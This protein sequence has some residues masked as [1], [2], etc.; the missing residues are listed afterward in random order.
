M[1]NAGMSVMG[2]DF[3][4]AKAR[5]DTSR[6]AKKAGHVLTSEFKPSEDAPDELIFFY[7]NEAVKEP[8]LE[9]IKKLI[10]KKNE[11]EMKAVWDKLKKPDTE[12]LY[13]RLVFA[14]YRGLNCPEPE[15]ITNKQKYK[16]VMKIQKKARELEELIEKSYWLSSVHTNSGLLEDLKMF[17]PEDSDLYAELNMKGVSVA[18]V[19]L[20]FAK[21]AEE[22]AKEPIP[23]ARAKTIRADDVYLVKSLTKHMLS[24][25]SEKMRK[26]VAIIASVVTGKTIAIDFVK[27]NTS[28]RANY[29]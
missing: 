23:I 15:K 27:T 10:S 22:I 17:A 19:L 8:V 28:K 11:P 12:F 29:I 3:D 25:Y 4:W 24:M 2:S 26:E 5:E 18:G 1:V 13:S 9:I 14:V 6:G 20:D 21:R 16:E 7:E